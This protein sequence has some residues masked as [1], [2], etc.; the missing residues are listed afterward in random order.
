MMLE[1]L[2]VILACV[3]SIHASYLVDTLCY[4]L[5]TVYKNNYN[6]YYYK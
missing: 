1:V 2:V 3:C 4:N 5:Y 6:E